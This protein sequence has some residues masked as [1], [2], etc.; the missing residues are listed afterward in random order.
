M[1][2]ER[3]QI[4]DDGFFSEMLPDGCKLYQRP[5]PPMI[6]MKVNKV[7][8]K[9]T[10]LRCLNEK[11]V[12]CFMKVLEKVCSVPDCEEASFDVTGIEYDKIRLIADIVNS[13]SVDFKKGGR[14]GFSG[15]S[16]SL[17]T[18]DVQYS[19]TEDRAIC[20]F[21]IIKEHAKVIYEYAQGK[22]K[23]NYY[24]LAIAVADSVIKSFN[25]FFESGI[26]PSVEPKK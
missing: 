9:I 12:D 23:I 14:K 2:Y 26:A 19:Q 25:Y 24:E 16:A 22:D 11:A 4:K 8:Y 20:T 18:S 6:E 10:D 5:E 21:G 1:K 7:K 13:V 15:C 3:V 17:I